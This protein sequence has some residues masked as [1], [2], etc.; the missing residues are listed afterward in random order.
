MELTSLKGIGEKTAGAFKRLG[1][2]CVSDLC[3]YYPREYEA[4]S[5]PMPLYEL[6]PGSI[7]VVE[8][9]LSKDATLNRFNG[10]TIVNAYLSDMTGRLQ[11]SWY[12]I[13]Y[14]KSNLKAGSR[15]VFRGRVYEKNGRLIM[16]QPKMY[17][18]ED[19]RERFEG[20]LIPVYPLT[21]G[22]NNNLLIKAVG[23]A[24]KTEDLASY[25][26]LG[27][28]MLEKADL[29]PEN[30]ALIRIHF[31]RS[32]KELMNARRR[33]AFDEFFM[34]LLAGARL[35]ERVKATRSNY[36]CRPEFRMINFIAGLPFE[37]TKGQS[38]AY[39]AIVHDLNSGNVMNRLIEGDVGSGKTIV[40]VLALMYMAFNGYQGAL[41]APTEVLAR[42]HAETIMKLF[43]AQGINLTVALITGSMTAKE[44]ETAYEHIKN[45]D[46]QIIIGTHALFQD[47]VEYK[48]LG[49]I[50]TDEQHRFGVA[51]REALS[52][53][54]E[55]PHTLIMSAT[56]IPRTLAI[57]LYGDIDVSVIDVLPEGR[58]PIKNCVVNADY[59]ERAYKFINDE[60]EKG[61]QA[62]V[63]C[64]AIEA[65][66]EEEGA[67]GNLENVLDYA[68]KLSTALKGRRVAYLH[69]QMKGAEKDDIM[70]RFKEGEIDVLVSTTV[71]EVGVDVPNAT[72]M[73]IEN[74][75]RFGL[76][77]LH[78][79]RGRVGR[80]KAQSYCIM[81]N[82]SDTEKAAERLDILNKSNDGFFIAEE[83]LR[84]RGPGDL[85]G[86]R[87]S[88][89][90]VFNL[91]DIYSDKEVLEK[92]K[93]TVAAVLGE[94]PGL[95]MDI[96]S[97]IRLRLDNYMDNGYTV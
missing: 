47:K 49:L 54:G 26:Y 83:D 5:V 30:E 17:S 63:V 42:Q 66:D 87:Q 23:E 14:I 64:P 90:M 37:L 60:I 84:L 6:R 24:L 76:A 22:V 88:G 8:G 68:K 11:L 92:A 28:N 21:K 18:P 91:A 7:G 56:P 44:K 74:A 13:P 35:R 45:G 59:R 81:I 16:S 96:H 52:Q 31:P 3:T 78:Q 25:E 82:T 72:V 57:I 61:H 33:I 50:V 38:D 85:F 32:N 41:M 53:K 10:L 97:R 94:D 27:D 20:R 9:T 79:L 67:G 62:Y 12:N 58:M 89:E 70:M 71:I 15:Y 36:K 65:E 77:Q 75:E 55:M 19:Y 80:G 86:V 40:A 29:M 48:S 51:Q 39:K 34:F 2:S 93:E 73:M 95:T 43:N 69:G 1:I 46:A 4:Y